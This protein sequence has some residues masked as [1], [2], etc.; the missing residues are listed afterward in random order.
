M[1]CNGRDKYESCSVNDESQSVVA[2]CLFQGQAAE[3]AEET[4]AVSD[5]KLI[6]L[7]RS[8]CILL[9]SSSHHLLR[10]AEW[11]KIKSSLMD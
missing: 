4:Q 7:S 11:T 3:R 10:V 8:L 2:S 9:P 6:D 5:Q 1:E